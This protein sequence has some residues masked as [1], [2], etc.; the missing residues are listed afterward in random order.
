MSDIKQA[1]LD[2]LLMEYRRLC[3]EDRRQRASGVTLAMD[4]IHKHLEGM[5][6]VPQIPSK[7]MIKRANNAIH[8]PKYADE[9]LIEEIAYFEMLAEFQR[10][11][12]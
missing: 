3:G 8:F 2:E 6:I 10:P 12:S 7:E 9:R 5:A 4:A 1:L 11:Q